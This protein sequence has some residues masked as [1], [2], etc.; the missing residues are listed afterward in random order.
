MLSENCRQA[1]KPAG[2]APTSKGRWIKRLASHLKRRPARLCLTT[3][4]AAKVFVETDNSGNA[5]SSAAKQ[6]AALS[7]QRR[8]SRERHVDFC[9]PSASGNFLHPCD[10]KLAPAP[11][12]A[13]RCAK[14]VLTCAGF[15]TSSVFLFCGARP[16]P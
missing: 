13:Q 9:W 14:N 15:F 8:P 12:Y 16:P 6:R 3:R 11:T 5:Y 4:R 7:A 1:D 2:Q 10:V